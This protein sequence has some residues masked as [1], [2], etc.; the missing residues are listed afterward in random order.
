MA[1]TYSIDIDLGTKAPEFELR[2]SVTNN[3]VN[4]YD[5]KGEKGT[6]VMFICNHCPFVK[7][8]ND[9][10]VR[11]ANDYRVLGFGFVA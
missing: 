6:V 7:H 5:I 9:E 2:D 1:R 10:I 4:L 8:V 11:L 3:L